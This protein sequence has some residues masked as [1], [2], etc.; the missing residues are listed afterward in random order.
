MKLRLLF[1]MMGCLVYAQTMS[2]YV[3]LRTDSAVI[4][5]PLR[6]RNHNE[7]VGRIL[8]SDALG[9]ATWQE[10]PVNT[11][12]WRV[13][14]LNS[15]RGGF[16]NT[17]TDG[18]SNT[19]LIGEQNNSGA[20]RYM[21]GMGWGLE[22]QGFG[23]SAVGMFNVIPTSNTSSWVGSDPIFIVGNGQSNAVR[24]NAMVIQKNGVVN[25][26][27]A[28]T[29]SSTYKLRIGGKV[30]ATDLLRAGSLAAANLSG[31]GIRPVCTDD[32]GNLIVCTPE[33]SSSLET[34]NVS[35]MGFLPQVTLPTYVDN[36]LRD[37]P[38]CLISF[39]NDT[40][41]PEAYLVAPVELP[42][43]YTVATVTM[44]YKRAEGGDLMLEFL[45]IPKVNAGPAAV[46]L[47]ILGNFSNGII[48]ETTV[49]MPNPEVI[50]NENFYYYLSVKAGDTWR[51]SN[52]ALRGVMFSNLKK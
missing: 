16:N 51:G 28:L 5:S 41:T 1:S 32:A 18:L 50:D 39:T 36:L 43:G 26:G 42:H 8:T 27:N 37:V 3:D 33:N 47:T 25:I 4:K 48:S 29:T 20:G 10:I 6:I 23:T 38:N 14:G 34:H 15:V 13:V 21:Y 24:S 46:I 49:A 31:T 44:H 35:A 52:L 7:A 45:R 22:L 40:K 2:Q 9:N 11:G 17:I 30:F 19:V 12:N